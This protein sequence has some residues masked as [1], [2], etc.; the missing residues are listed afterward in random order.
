M[1]PIKPPKPRLPLKLI[2][3]RQPLHLRHEGFEWFLD[4]GIWGTRDGSYREARV[5]RISG[6]QSGEAGA[7]LGV[8]L[9]EECNALRLEKL[10]MP[11]AHSG[12]VRFT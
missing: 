4:I 12:V 6:P 7:A 10:V 11:P 3:R 1:T 5:L 9:A 8:V 2:H